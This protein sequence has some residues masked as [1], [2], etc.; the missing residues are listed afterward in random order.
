VALALLVSAAAGLVARLVPYDRVRLEVGGFEGPMLRGDWSRADRAN[1]DPEAA[2]GGPASLYFREAPP[3]VEVVL[4]FTVARGPLRVIVRATTRIRSTV[5]VFFGVD[6]MGDIVLPPGRL[7]G[8]P[9][10]WPSRAVEGLVAGEAPLR[11]ALNVRP[12]P[13]VRRSEEELDRPGVLVDYVEVEAP[14]RLRLDGRAAALVAAGPLAF[15]LLFLALGLRPAA[16]LGAETVLAVLAVSAARL[17]PAS[18]VL[19]LPRLVPAALIAGGAAALLLRRRSETSDAERSALA[20]MVAVGVLAHGSVVFF[21]NH[22]PPDLDIHVRRTLDL[23]NVPFTYGALLRYG[24]QLP[25][26]SQ[27]IGQATTALGD[28]TLIPYSPLP[29]V[30]FLGLNRLGLD[31]RWAMTVFDAALA[32]LVAPLVFLAAGH[33]WDRTAAWTAA[34]L[35]AFDLAVW[36]QLGR[37]H[38]PAVFGGALGTAALLHLVAGAERLGEP[39]RRVLAA[40]VLGLAVLGYSSLMVLFGLFGLALIALVVADARGLATPARRGLVM[41]LVGGGAIAGVLFYFHYV[42]GLLRGAG[43]VEA[44]PDLFPGKTFFIF[45]NESRQSLRL[46]TLGFSVPLGAGLLAAPWAIARARAGAR[47]VLVSWLAA[48]GLVMVLKE[49]FLFPK[50]LRWAKEDQFVSPALALCLAGAVAGLP[51]RWMRW[52]AGALVIGVALALEARDFAHHANSLRL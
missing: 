38:V 19:A 47:P 50:L 22:Q 14:G 33:A 48:W 35:Y 20:A 4:P 24:S 37:V 10:P 27:D 42:P 28:A 11:L 6:R 32:M 44:A 5:A 15:A 1:V 21:P 31:L 39:R 25:T 3:H 26:A 29:Y 30:V 45:H 16:V 34:L 8:T 13:L 17:A 51:R 18:A 41:A 40:A 12:T 23:A 43:A 36:H 2:A 52:A 7:E 46:W 9:G 49:P